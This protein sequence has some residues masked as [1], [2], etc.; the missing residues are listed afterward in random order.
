MAR[1]TAR[2][3]LVEIDQEI[4]R[5]VDES[6]GRV[7]QLLSRERDRL[8]AAATRLLEKEVLEGK[9]LRALLGIRDTLAPDA[10]Q[11]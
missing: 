5:I 4:K 11:G 2:K 7:H 10:S 1:S 6:E 3:R 8:T 9:E